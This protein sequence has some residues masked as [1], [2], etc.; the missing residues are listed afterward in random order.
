MRKRILGVALVVAMAVSVA[1]TKAIVLSP[2]LGAS[3]SGDG[4]PATCD[5]APAELGK[6]R[7]A[8]GGGELPVTPWVDENGRE[9]PVSDFRGEGLVLNFWATWCAPCVKEMPALDRLAAEADA[10]GFRVVA[11]SADREGAAA[12]RQFYVV[13]AVGHLPV[14]L[15]RTSRVARAAGVEGLPTTIFY[16]SQGR[17]VGRVV[18]AAEWDAP[19]V[20]DFLSTCVGSP[21]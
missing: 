19:A 11:L 8:A 13:N 9:R 20:V 1:S 2:S 3:G 12:V 4:V 6:Y 15:D 16:D 18:G 5:Q 7:P 10:R 21:R 17:E 14:A